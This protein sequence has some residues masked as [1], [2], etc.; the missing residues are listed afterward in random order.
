MNVVT[1]F[2][3][4]LLNKIVYIEQLHG[5]VQGIL[6]CWLKQTLYIFKQA[7]RVWYLVICNFLKEKDFIATNFNQNIFISINKHLFLA[8][9]VDDL[10]LFGTNETQL[11]ILKRKLYSHFWITSLGDVSHYL[12]IE[13][14]CNQK[15]DTLMFFQT[16]YLKMIL[17]QF[18]ISDCNPIST[19]M[20]SGLP[21]T[22]ISSFLDY[23][24]LL[25]I[26][27]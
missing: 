7:P 10:L 5:F 6:V 8:I 26:I 22:I 16:V 17:K 13:I 14:C 2:L 25:D 19:S 1:T 20:D 12:K 27:V 4:S 21:N 23:L 24:A 3:Y 9:Y 15:R 11:D 18:G